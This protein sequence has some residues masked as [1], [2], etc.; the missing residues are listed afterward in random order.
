MSKDKYNFEEEC[1]ALEGH[2]LPINDAKVVVNFVKKN[3]FTRFRTPRALISY[4]GT[5]FC[6]KLLDNLLAKYGSNT[7]SLRLI[8]HKLVVKSRYQK[9]K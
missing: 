5:H 4:K 1:D 6:N 7:R 3:I 8:N 2:T 9:E